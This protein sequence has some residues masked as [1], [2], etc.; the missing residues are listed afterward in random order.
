MPRDTSGLIQKKSQSFCPGIFQNQ[1][2]LIRARAISCEGGRKFAPPKT[3]MSLFEQ[4]D[5]SRVPQHVAIIMDGNGRW[6][7]SQGKERI[8]GHSNGVE[9]VRASLKAATRAGVKYL[10]LYAF[11]TENWARPKEE[12]EALMNLLV[13]TI[14]AEVDELDKN[15]VRLMAIGDISGLPRPCQEELL[16]G[17]DR[18]AHH[19]RTTLILALNYSA[20]W[21][22]VNAVKNLLREN[23]DPESLD[24]KA[25]SMHLST[26]V[27]TGL[28]LISTG[29]TVPSFRTACK[30]DPDPIGR[31]EGLATYPAR[32]P[33]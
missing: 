13:H 3:N 33:R 9:S 25:V 31:A 23:A 10:T 22:M 16:K 6:A 24:E 4:I 11:S 7:Q 2:C 19:S 8:F 12:V 20:R 21:D 29:K 32:C 17:M 26:R 27:S 15:Q 14:V 18:T 1:C 28:R 5:Q 30:S